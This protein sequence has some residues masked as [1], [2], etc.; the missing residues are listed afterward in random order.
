M[1]GADGADVGVVALVEGAFDLDAA[2]EAVV[3]GGDVV[4]GGFSPGLVAAEAELGGALHEMEFGPLAAE[5]GMEDVLASGVGVHGYW[6]VSSGLKP[7]SFL[8]VLTR[9]LRQAQGRR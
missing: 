6:V 7:L 9:P 4:G 8:D 2:E 1:A 3:V 5:L